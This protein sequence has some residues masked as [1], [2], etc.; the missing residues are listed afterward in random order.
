MAGG[1]SPCHLQQQESLNLDLRP[2][3]RSPDIVNMEAKKGNGNGFWIPRDWTMN[4][5]PILGPYRKFVDSCACFRTV[6]STNQANWTIELVE[7]G[8]E[9]TKAVWEV[10]LGQ[11]YQKCIL[12]DKD[13]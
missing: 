6:S 5:K 11:A 1:C 9:A 3:L 2:H 4:F 8:A 12:E 7:G 10:L 13:I